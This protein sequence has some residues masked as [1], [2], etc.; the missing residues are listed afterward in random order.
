VTRL[1]RAAI[2]AAAFAAGA[3]CAPS[4]RAGVTLRVLNWAPGLELE[5]EQ[6]IADRFAAA[7]PGVAVVV[8]SVV[9]NY[10]EKLAAAIASG[11]PP[12]V[13]LLDVPDIPAFVDRGLVLDFAPYLARVGYDRGAVF[14]EV[15]DVF[16][17]GAR[18]HALPKDFTPMVIYV[19]RRVFAEAGVAPPGPEGWTWD[20]FLA[21][22]RAL[23]RDRDGDGRRDVYAIDFPRDLYAWVAW[24]WSAGGDIMSPDGGRTSGFL[25][26]P[27]AV[28]TFRFLTDLALTHEVTPPVQYTLGGDMARTGRFF[29]GTQA[30]LISGHWS[31]PQ[32]VKYAERGALDLG[33]APIP[34]R[35]GADPAT[36]IYVSGWA[37]PVN[38]KNKRL[39]VALAAY[40][41]GPEAQWARAQTRLGIPALRAVAERAAAA[42]PTGVER[43]FLA[44]V[45]R[46]RMP[47]GARVRDFHRVERASFDI[48]DRRLLRGDD[49][50]R[51]ATDV[52]AAL[53]RQLAR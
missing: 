51:S 15:L 43:A 17:R 11:T 23:S 31:M 18:L 1:I 49:V 46:G 34:H 38:V 13:F 19:N 53:D 35:A 44:Q 8:E 47:W 40:L 52:A 5:L 22:A 16:S 26:G 4:A 12:D 28:D 42:D 7:H 36:A 41:A 33:V 25:D 3:G 10:G 48:M 32:L 20:A 45:P 37:V 39:A 27:A 6:R 21:A 29:A 2:V 24:V 14:P 50:Q 30:M 9:N